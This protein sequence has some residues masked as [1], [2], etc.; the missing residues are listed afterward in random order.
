GLGSLDSNV[1]GAAEVPGLGPVRGIFAGAQSNMTAAVGFDGSVRAWGHANF[2]QS[3]S[4][5]YNGTQPSPVLIPGYAGATQL[6]FGYSFSCAVMNDTTVLCVGTNDQGQ[7][8]DGTTTHRD[9]PV[10]VVGL[11]DIVQ[12]SAGDDHTCAL[13]ANGTVSCWGN[14]DQNQLANGTHLKSSV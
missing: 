14:N 4:P 8:G 7:L 1:H 2:D 11:S 5:T 10:P 3:G 12:V 9:S 13:H 6:S